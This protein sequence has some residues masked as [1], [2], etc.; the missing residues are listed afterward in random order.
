MNL[1][2]KK[3]YLLTIVINEAYIF[4]CPVE[5]HGKCYK[6]PCLDRLDIFNLF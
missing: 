5:V 2:I 3:A 1:T 6:P 4:L